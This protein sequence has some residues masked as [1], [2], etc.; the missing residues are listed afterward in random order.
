MTCQ[1]S[2]WLIHHNKGYACFGSAGG[3]DI[4]TKAGKKLYDR[5]DDDEYDQ[6]YVFETGKDSCYRILFYFR[7]MQLTG[8]LIQKVLDKAEGT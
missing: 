8:K 5:D 6:D 1:L 7:N 4:F 2:Q 3:T